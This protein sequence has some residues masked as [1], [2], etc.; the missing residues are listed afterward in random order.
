MS[1]KFPFSTTMRTVTTIPHG[2]HVAGI[3]ARQRRQD[4]GHSSRGT[5]HRRPARAARLAFW[6]AL[7][8]A[9]DDMA[10]LRP[11]VVNLS[12]GQTGGMDNEAD[13]VATSV[14]QEPAGHRGESVNAAAGNEYSAGMAACRVPARPTRPTPFYV[15]VV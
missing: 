7:L 13:S 4:H 5:G 11:D 14:L 3:A 9:L 1:E 6:T 2:T 10:V 15:G 8:A 12:L